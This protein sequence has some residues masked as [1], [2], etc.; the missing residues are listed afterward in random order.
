MSS[1]GLVMLASVSVNDVVAVEIGLLNPAPEM[2]VQSH[3]NIS[4][5]ALWDGTQP[6][7]WPLAKRRNKGA[8]LEILG[9]GSKSPSQE[10]GNDAAKE[11]R[12][13]HHYTRTYGKPENKMLKI[14]T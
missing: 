13:Q 3:T 4:P 9:I 8:G 1:T 12:E 5:R 7:G 6:A 2:A 10:Q 11:L 14:P